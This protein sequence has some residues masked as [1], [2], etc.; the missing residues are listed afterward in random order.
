MQLPTTLKQVVEGL[1]KESLDVAQGELLG[2][3]DEVLARYGV[4]RPTLRQAAAIVAQEQLLRVKR[5]VG[6]GYIAER[7][8]TR[9]VAHIVALFLKTRKTKLDQIVSSMKPIRA[10]LAA[11]AAT[12]LSE[13]SRKAFVDFL[14]RDARVSSDN[15]NSRTLFRSQREFQEILGEASQNQVLALYLDILLDL[16]TSLPPEH[17]VYLGRPER[18][19]AFRRMRR[20]LV[21]AILDGDPEMARLCSH[22]TSEMSMRW[23]RS[24]KNSI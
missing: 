17:D 20:R 16:A 1:R 22:R 21:E 10:E 2:S 15:L 9:T 6:G 12:S 23:T 3:E 18:L 19:H 14:D 7:P 5:G 13:R 11:L 4:A 24:D 8:T